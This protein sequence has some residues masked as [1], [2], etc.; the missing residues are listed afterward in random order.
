MANVEG[1]R[2]Y[3]VRTGSAPRRKISADEYVVMADGVNTMGANRR[4]DSAVGW[5]AIWAL[6]LLAGAFLFRRSAAFYWIEAPLFVAA[7]T[8]ILWMSD[9]Q[10]RRC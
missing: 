4:R 7:I 1:M 10:A 9:A 8:H 5:S 3:P 2:A 6:A